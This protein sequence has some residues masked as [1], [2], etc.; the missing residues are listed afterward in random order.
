MLSAEIDVVANHADTGKIRYVYYP[1]LDHGP[2]QKTYEA[3]ECAGEQG[4]EH[5]WEIHDLFYYQQSELW[6]ADSERYVRFA[7]SA[8]VPDLERFRQCLDSGQYAAKTIDLDRVRRANSIRLRPTFD[9]DGQLYPGAQRYERLA[10]LIDEAL[11][12]R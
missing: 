1:I 9:L 6:S 5:F 11:A 2:T 12:A 4:A 10:Q 3:A 7:E 8:G